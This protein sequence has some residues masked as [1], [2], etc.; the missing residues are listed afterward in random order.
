MSIKVS[1][2]APNRREAVPADA[3]LGFGR[4]FSDHMFLCDYTSADKWHNPRIEPRQPIALDPAAAT[5]HYAQEIFEG[6]KAYR[7]ADGGIRLFRHRA[8]LERMNRSAERMCMPRID[9]DAVDQAIQQLVVLDQRW[10]PETEGCSLYIRPTM[11][12]TE[13]FLGVRP[14]EQYLFFVILSPVGSYYPKGFSTISIMVQSE[15]VRAVPRGVGAAKTGGNYAASLKAQVDAKQHGLSQVL[16]LDGKENRFVEEVG[17]SNIFF[18]LDDEIVTPP[19]GGSILPGIT[20]D[21]VLELLRHWGNCKVS[22]RPI[23]IDEVIDASKSGRLKEAFGTGTAAVISPI[24]E[25]HYNGTRHGIAQ[26][27][28]G[29]VSQRLFDYIIGLQYGREEDRFGWIERI[30]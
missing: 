28:I 15:Y 7:G 14:S 17:T 29:P 19:L 4:Y 20:R 2:A 26:G 5:L 27:E 8:N 30:A 10:I 16:W 21:S 6:L 23:A 25:L 12:A 9:I 3:E 24:G 22:E 18:V 13:A 1:V 11:I